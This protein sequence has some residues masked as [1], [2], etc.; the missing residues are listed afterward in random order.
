M[1]LAHFESP[2]KD[3]L[4]INRSLAA[5]TTFASKRLMA[6]ADAVRSVQQQEQPSS[7][8]IQ[9]KGE[10]DFGKIG[11][12]SGGAQSKNNAQNSTLLSSLGNF[13]NPTLLQESAASN[14]ILRL[15]QEISKQQCCQTCGK[16][17]TGTDL[18]TTI[19]SQYLKSGS[20]EMS[21]NAPVGKYL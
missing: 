16:D 21:N 4:P 15:F 10:I 7:L 8:P 13:V 5:S 14:L 19:T 18:M 20:M 11:S 9:S 3:G 17:N 6:A 1:D 2:S 12:G